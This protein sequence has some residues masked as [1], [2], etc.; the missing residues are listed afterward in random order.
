VFSRRRHEH[1][2]T[3]AV[4]Y[5]RCHGERGRDILSVKKRPPFELPARRRGFAVSVAGETL[6]KDFAARLDARRGR[7]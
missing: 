6:R 2:I 1:E 5:A 3:E 4:A 7:A